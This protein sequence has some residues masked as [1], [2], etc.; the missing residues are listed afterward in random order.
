[1]QSMF[2]N[3]ILADGQLEHYPDYVCIKG[4]LPNVFLT[5]KYRENFSWMEQWVR[6]QGSTPAQLHQDCDT[7]E[8]WPKIQIQLTDDHKPHQFIYKHQ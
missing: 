4:H 1:M 6:S 5:W 2:I 7:V 8:K 3:I